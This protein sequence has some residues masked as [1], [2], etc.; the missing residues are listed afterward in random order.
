LNTR[1]LYWMILLCCGSFLLP[2]QRGIAQSQ[3]NGSITNLP[4]YSPSAYYNTAKPGDVMMQINIWGFVAKPGRYEVPVTTDLIQLISFAGGPQEYSRMDNVKITRF[5]KIDTAVV[6]KEIFV[7]LSDA[8]KVNPAS[9]KLCQ[10]DVIEIDHT[11]WFVWKDII[12]IITSVA[13]ITT[14]IVEVIYLSRQQ[15]T[16]NSSAY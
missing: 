9:F 6:I 13:L 10:G 7:N 11:S 3:Q 14:A 8:T 12:P 4:V 2:L 15:N 5:E 1:A 16:S